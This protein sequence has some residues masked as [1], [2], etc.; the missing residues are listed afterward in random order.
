MEATAVEQKLFLRLLILDSIVLNLLPDGNSSR[1]C[2]IFE[3]TLGFLFEFV[4]EF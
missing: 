2:D 3:D 1:V 4:D